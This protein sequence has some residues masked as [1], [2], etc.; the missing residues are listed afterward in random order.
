M[1]SSVSKS[2]LVKVFRLSA[3]FG[4]L[5]FSTL[6]TVNAQTT[7]FAQ[8]FEVNGTQDFVFTNNGGSGDFA[9]IPGGS[10]VFF[11]Y[12]NLPT[13]PPSLQGI[14]SAHMFVTTTTTQPG[15]VAGG[16][17][18]QPLN[19]TVTVQII[20]DTPAPVGTGG[21]SRTN[22][23][24]AVFSTAG[25][26]PAIVGS[27]GSATL[28]AST[29][30][31]NVTFTSNFLIFT[32]TTERNLG[33][34]FSSVTPAMALGLGG[35]LQST[36]AAGSG[37]FASNP[38]PVPPGPTAAAVS[39][40]GRVS[41]ANG[42]GLRNSEVTLLNSNGTFMTARTTNFGHFLFDGVASGQSVIISVRSKRYTFAPQ[43]ISLQDSATD[44]N[45]VANP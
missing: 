2:Q 30:G 33:L 23:L 22:L 8:F 7:T 6:L 9:A 20:R 4:L 41:T 36:T 15:S 44:I 32:A 26:T 12:Q 19:Q 16:V 3:I 40:S 34:S 13:L 17:V 14:Q 42:R 28:N 45:F 39:V 27:G 24:T 43:V 11:L 29:P 5:L 18:T 25:N 31:H 1:K 38:L 35:F 10:P 21:G 37:T